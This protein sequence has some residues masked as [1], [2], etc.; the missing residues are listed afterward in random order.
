[1]HQGLIVLGA[2]ARRRYQAAPLRQLTG[3][4]NIRAGIF[5]G[6]VAIRKPVA[7]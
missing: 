2:L 3:A 5:S 6:W 1:M 7:G 4:P